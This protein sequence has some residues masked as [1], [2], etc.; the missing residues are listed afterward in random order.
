M[1]RNHNVGERSLLDKAK[2]AVGLGDKASTNTNHTT[3]Y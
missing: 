2:D 3:N 1:F